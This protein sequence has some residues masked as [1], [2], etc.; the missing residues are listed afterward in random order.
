MDWSGQAW[1]AGGERM[2]W[3][4]LARLGLARQARCDQART[5]GYDRADWH[6][7]AGEGGNAWRGGQWQDRDWQIMAGADSPGVM[8][9][10]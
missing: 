4:G 10:V 1:M 5:G 7:I 3:Y 6:G 8:W 2:V 9:W